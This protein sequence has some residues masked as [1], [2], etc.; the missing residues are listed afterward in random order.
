LPPQDGSPPAGLVELFALHAN[1]GPLK[2]FDDDVKLAARAI[3]TPQLQYC[4]AQ[5]YRRN[6]QDAKANVAR[7]A[8]IE[9]SQTLSDHFH[10]G[11]FLLR[12]WWLDSSRQEYEQIL[13][14]PTG[15]EPNDINFHIQCPRLS[16]MDSRRHPS[17]PGLRPA[18]RAGHGHDG[19]RQSPLG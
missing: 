6:G 4:L 12:R 5:M 17:R 7:R 11:G 9:A 18:H 2:G 13:K 8:A 16:C 1:F 3:D 15:P 14:L 10:I 19:T